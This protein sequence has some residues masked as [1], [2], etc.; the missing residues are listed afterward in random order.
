[1]VASRRKSERVCVLHTR[2]DHFLQ[3]RWANNP[4]H[5]RPNRVLLRQTRTTFHGA[6]CRIRLDRAG[7]RGR[8]M[9]ATLI[10]AVRLFGAISDDDVPLEPWQILQAYGVQVPDIPMLRRLI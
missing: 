7:E 4:A 6:V 2:A 9:S 5:Q 3:G 1:M 8:D 10:D